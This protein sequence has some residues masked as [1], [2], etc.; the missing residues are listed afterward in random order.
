[1]A[2]WL[3]PTTPRSIAS[4]EN[5]HMNQP[6]LPPIEEKRAAALRDI[7]SNTPTVFI[8]AVW[9]TCFPTFFSFFFGFKKST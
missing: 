2:T 3:P 9:F 8:H 7:T 1:M 4:Y 5:A 6:R